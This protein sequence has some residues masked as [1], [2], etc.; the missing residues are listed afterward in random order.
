MFNWCRLAKLCL[1]AEFPDFELLT[2]FHIFNLP[3]AKDDQGRAS[4]ASSNEHQE[5]IATI[6]RACKLDVS[7]LREGY[8]FVKPIA[9]VKRAA[10]P[11]LSNF[12]AWRVAVEHVRRSRKDTQPRVVTLIA[13]L[14]RYGA[15]TSSSSGVERNFFMSQW[16]VESRKA[17]LS[18]ALFNDELKILCDIHDSDMDELC[19]AARQIWHDMK[20]GNKRPPY[21]QR[22][23]HGLK[24]KANALHT[25]LDGWLKRRRESVGQMLTLVGAQNEARMTVKKMRPCGRAWS[26]K[27]Q[28]EAIFQQAKHMT[29]LVDAI[30]DGTIDVDKLDVESLRIVYDEI[31]RREEACKRALTERRNKLKIFGLPP[32]STLRG[33]Q[34]FIEGDVQLSA[35]DLQAAQQAHGWRRAADRTQAD[36]YIVSSPAHPGQ[37]TGWCVA[38]RGGTLTTS[39]Y[40]LSNGQN[41]AAIVFK[42][43][44]RTEQKVFVTEEFIAAHPTISELLHVC[45][46]QPRTRWRWLA[47]MDEVRAVN[48]KFMAKS[49]EAELIVFVSKAQF[50]RRPEVPGLSKLR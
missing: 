37:R 33:K 43:A 11:N 13:A 1:A 10:E 29:Y 36:V 31:C 16:A 2:K 50:N 42:S 41:G 9:A 32:Q 34:V 19:L 5:A 18:D 28:K 24:R 38:L 21:R 25:S 20:Y 8:E 49:R 27:L 30:L 40:L 39:E 7:L 22:I 17:W 26:D 48:D 12:A 35:S 45:G 14:T 44:T 6:A 46:H 4:G 15:W 47:D 23:D 3:A